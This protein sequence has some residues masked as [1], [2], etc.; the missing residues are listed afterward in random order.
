MPK[1]NPL[2]QDADF[3]TQAIG[4]DFYNIAREYVDREHGWLLV[5]NEDKQLELKRIA[6]HQRDKVRLR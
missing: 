3:I 5:V 4:G 2:M 1:L 6:H